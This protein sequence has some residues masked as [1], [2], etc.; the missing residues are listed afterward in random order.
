[1][2]TIAQEMSAIDE[3]K[4]AWYD[5]LTEK[6]QKDLQMW[7]VMRWAACTISNNHEANAYCLRMINDQVNVNFND[8]RHYPDL[9]FRLMQLAGTGTTKTHSWIKPM[10][11]KKK[12]LA[13]NNKLVAFYETL[14]PF[15]NDEELSMVIGMYTKAEIK[16]ELESHGLTAK[17]IKEMVK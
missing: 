9:Q 5:N 2:P 8:M 12:G 16:A 1:M 3:R 13:A 10:L 15:M 6:E 7:V 14:Y 17:L 11:K 4:F